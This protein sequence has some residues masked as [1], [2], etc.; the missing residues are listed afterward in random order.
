MNGMQILRI[1]NAVCSYL[2]V[3]NQVVLKIKNSFAEITY[4]DL[5]SLLGEWQEKLDHAFLHSI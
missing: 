2:D 5:V 1:P 3:L 4:D